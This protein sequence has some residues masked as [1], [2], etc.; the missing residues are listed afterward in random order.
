MEEGEVKG[1]IIF[2]KMKEGGSKGEGASSC[3]WFC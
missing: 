2:L 3:G 1:N